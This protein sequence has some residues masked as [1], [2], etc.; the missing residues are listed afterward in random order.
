MSS[1]ASTTSSRR[2]SSRSHLRSVST[3]HSN[4]PPLSYYNTTGASPSPVSPSIYS[5]TP[6]SLLTSMPCYLVPATA[7]AAA[8]QGSSAGES[9]SDTNSDW[10]PATVDSRSSVSPV[11]SRSGSMAAVWEVPGKVWSPC[12]CARVCVCVRACVRVC[13]LGV[14]ECVLGVHVCVTTDT[15]IPGTTFPHLPIVVPRLSN[16]EHARSRADHRRH[17]GNHPRRLGAHGPAPGRHA[18][19]TI[20]ARAN[21][22]CIHGIP[23]QQAGLSQ[24]RPTILV[25]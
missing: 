14:H 13:V 4:L 11:N 20:H 19:G 7:A 10:E 16:H 6:H 5:T 9:G 21:G 18:H 24:A 2:G 25:G 23:A 17:F 3:S 1:A 22:P 15:P 8:A 12:V